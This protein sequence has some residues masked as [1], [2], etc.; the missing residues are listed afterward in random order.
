MFNIHSHSFDSVRFWF[1]IKNGKMKRQQ[2]GTNRFTLSLG[3]ISKVTSAF[4][5]MEKTLIKRVKNC[6]WQFTFDDSD[7]CAIS[8]A[9]AGCDQTESARTVGQQLHK[10]RERYMIVGLQCI[11]HS[12][13]KVNAHLRVHS[14]AETWSKHIMESDPAPY[15]RQVGQCKS[16]VYQE[17]SKDLMPPHGE[18]IWRLLLW[19]G[20]IGCT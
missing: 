7:V 18:A 6:G 15:S 1:S 19:F 3:T 2:R 14:S 16:S 10:E 8:N 17:R 13:Q 12:L 20:S 5:S 4:R 11:N 9:N